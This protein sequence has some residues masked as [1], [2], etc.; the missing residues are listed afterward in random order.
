MVKEWQVNEDNIS[1]SRE[2]NDF[3]REYNDYFVGT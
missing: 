1:V 3:C 2:Y